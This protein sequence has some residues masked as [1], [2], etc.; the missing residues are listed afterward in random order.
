MN[1]KKRYFWVS[2]VKFTC[3]VETDDIPGKACVIIGGAPIIRKFI[4]QPFPNLV[5]WMTKLGG[6]KVHEYR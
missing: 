5:K 1:I 3:Y 6:F 2:C 4:G